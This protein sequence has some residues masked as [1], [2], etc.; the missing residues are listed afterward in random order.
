MDKKYF[1]SLFSKLQGPER[2]VVK[3]VEDRYAFIASTENTNDTIGWYYINSQIVEN[4]LREKGLSWC[5]VFETEPEKSPCIYMFIG[6]GLT[7][8]FIIEELKESMERLPEGTKIYYETASFK[9]IDIADYDNSISELEK[10]L[11][12]RAS[13]VFRV[14]EP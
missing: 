6:E 11:T 4:S 10:E 2:V 12:R 9:S 14:Y 8:E 7:K 1:A 3:F 5:Y 13:D